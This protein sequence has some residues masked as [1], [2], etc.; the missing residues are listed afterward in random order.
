LAPAEDTRTQ[1]EEQPMQLSIR[2]VSIAF[3][4]F[5]APATVV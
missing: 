2:T 1:L 4:A 3:L 5:I